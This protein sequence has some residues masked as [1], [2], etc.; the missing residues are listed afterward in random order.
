[1]IDCYNFVT[2]FSN[3]AGRPP[4]SR[5]WGGCGVVVCTGGAGWDGEVYVVC[6]RRC[7]DG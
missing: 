7:S 1:M 2:P 3:S 5:L 4:V 6:A